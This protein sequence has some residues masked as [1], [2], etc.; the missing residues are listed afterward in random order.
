MPE[1]STFIGEIPLSRV[2][3]AVAA[4][5][6]VWYLGSYLISPLGK[7][8]GPFLAGKPAQVTLPTHSFSS[9]YL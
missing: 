2:L 5:I 9:D 6:P 7:F 8:P 3:Y 1:L 4:I